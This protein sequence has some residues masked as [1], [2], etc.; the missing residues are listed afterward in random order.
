MLFFILC[1]VGCLSD[2]YLR[3]G[4][5]E[6]EKEYVYVQDNFIEGETEPEWPIWVDS[7]IQPQTSN[8]VDIIWAIDGSG[9]MN[10][11]YEKVLQGISD[12]LSSLPM[13]SWRL[14]I[15]SMDPGDAMT[16]EGL[17]LLPGDTYQDALDM[18]LTNVNG[19]SETGFLSVQKFL[20][21]NQDAQQWL[22][23]DAAL[24]VVFVSDEDDGSV[25]YI[26]S[27][28]SF[29]TWLRNYRQNVYVSSII[30]FHPDE[31]Q[32]NTYSHMTGFRYIDLTNLFSGYLIDIC[33][34]DWSQGVA[35]ASNQITPREY[36]DLTYVPHDPNNI[37]VFVNGIEFPNWTYDAS[38]NRVV[39]SIIP[40]EN[41]LVEIAYY[42]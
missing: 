7:F 19:T 31:S 13:I 18:F 6:T 41:S 33:S 11:E 8:G 40:P 3:Y 30:N 28:S 15:I 16:I 5:L 25:N 27:V 35:D 39:F 10:N 42:Y 2:H 1:W 23:S 26:P 38:L 9:S 29:E 36:Y 14:M 21:E 22:R 12:M 32:C 20:L 37:Y 34:Y 24:L 4:V 17:P